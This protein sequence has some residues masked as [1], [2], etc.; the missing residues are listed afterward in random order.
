MPNIVL[1][2]HGS[3]AT[4]LKETAELIIG[5]ADGIEC[6]EMTSSLSHDDAERDLTALITRCRSLPDR[7]TALVDIQGGSPFNICTQQLLEH[8]DFT[9]LTGVNLPML[10]EASTSSSI[11]GAS[12][13]AAGSAAVVHVNALLHDAGT[14]S[15]LEDKEPTDD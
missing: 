14:A 9:L 6:F 1:A 2:T 11:D 8:G 13:T 15:D 12:L 4:A 5:R 10:L 3:F 7:L